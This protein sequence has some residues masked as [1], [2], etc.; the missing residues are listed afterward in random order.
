MSPTKGHSF[1]VRK[2]KQPTRYIET[3]TLIMQNEATEEL[4]TNE[5]TR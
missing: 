3:K 5:E 4:V 2:Y 1:K